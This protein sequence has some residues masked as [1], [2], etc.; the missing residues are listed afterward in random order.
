MIVPA[1][2]VASMRSGEIL[3][4]VSTSG[5]GIPYVMQSIK[6]MLRGRYRA[7]PQKQCVR[8]EGKNHSFDHAGKCTGFSHGKQMFF[9]QTFIK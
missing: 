8:L 6:R 5:E 1:L 3:F 4:R 7:A 2:I 9:S